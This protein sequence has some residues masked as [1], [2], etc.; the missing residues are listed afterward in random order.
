MGEIKI[1]VAKSLTDD[2]HQKLT[3]NL[4]LEAIFIFRSFKKIHP[5]TQTFKSTLKPLN[6]TSPLWPDDF[7]DYYPIVHEV[8]A[9]GISLAK[10]NEKYLWRKY[11]RNKL[12][13]V[14][15]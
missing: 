10:S 4:T 11:R 8:I 6:E 5:K 1:Y 15:V 3:L 12:G 2:Y 7:I 9:R 14:T 13:V